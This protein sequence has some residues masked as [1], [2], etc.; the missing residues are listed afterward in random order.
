MEEEE[1]IENK[2]NQAILFINNAKYLNNILSSEQKLTFYAFYK[3]ATIGPC[4]ISK[5]WFDIMGRAK[6]YI[7][8]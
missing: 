5:P 7:F 3:Q 4:L 2:F 1:D 6:W 8:K